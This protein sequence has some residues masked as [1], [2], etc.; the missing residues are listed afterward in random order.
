MS[1][2]F[3]IDEGCIACSCL[4]TGSRVARVFGLDS[5]N[6]LDVLNEG[7]SSM[8]SIEGKI[9]RVFELDSPNPLVVLNEG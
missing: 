3:I 4:W 6:P 2:N 9:V 5:S 1:S 7:W 8:F